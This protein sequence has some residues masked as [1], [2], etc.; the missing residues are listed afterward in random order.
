M[1]AECRHFVVERIRAEAG[2]GYTATLDGASC[3]I[4]GTVAGKASLHAS[5]APALD[6]A[7][8]RFSLLPA[9]MGRFTLQAHTRTAAIRVFLP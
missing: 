4:W 6:L 5:A 7:P 9:T 2:A 3:E 8:A 1:I